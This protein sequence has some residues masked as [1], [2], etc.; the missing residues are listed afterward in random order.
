VPSTVFL[1][2]ICISILSLLFRLFFLKKIMYFD[3]KRYCYEVLAKG[4]VLFVLS[5]IIIY[6]VK[7]HT[8]MTMNFWIFLTETLAFCFIIAGLIFFIGMNKKE[9]AFVI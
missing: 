4:V 2:S 1:I 8:N 6:L 9:R 3:L 7:K 5:F